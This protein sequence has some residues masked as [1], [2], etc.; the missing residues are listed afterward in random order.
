MAAVTLNKNLRHEI[1]RNGINTIKADKSFKDESVEIPLSIMHEWFENQEVVKFMEANREDVEKLLQVVNKNLPENSNEIETPIIVTL[2]DH[3][4]SFDPI[5]H[6]STKQVTMFDP[7]F[8]KGPTKACVLVR[9]V[10]NGEVPSTFVSPKGFIRQVKQEWHSSYASKSDNEH[11]EATD[12]SEEKFL[13][14]TWEQAPECVQKAIEDY[15]PRNKVT[16]KQAQI[17]RDLSDLLEECRTVGQF[18]KAFPEGEHLLPDWVINK[19]H[20]KTASKK[21]TTLDFDSD[22]SHVKQSILINKIGAA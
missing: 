16:E 8:N 13:S 19:L 7:K 17:K 3:L 21:K 1:V 15:F 14:L 9:G 2:P 10:Y 18:L 20:Q 11:R 5:G 12:P 4:I 22:L 6:N